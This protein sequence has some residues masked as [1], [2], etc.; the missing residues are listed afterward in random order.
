MAQLPYLVAAVLSVA[1]LAVVGYHA[2]PDRERLWLIG[3]AVG[4]G[5]LLEQGAIV[6]FE[7]YTY[8]LD[9]FPMT[10]LDVPLTI[11]FAWAAIVYS[12]LE[13]AR[14]LDL[15]TSAIPAFTA[16][17]LLHVDL[18]IDAVAIRIPFWTW[19]NSGAWFGVPINN[20]VGWYLIGLLFS[21][22]YL[23]AHDRIASLPLRAGVTLTAAVASLLVLLELWLRVVA[24]H[25]VIARALGFAVMVGAALVVVAGAEIDPRPVSVL[26]SAIPVT[27]HLFYLAVLLGYGYHRDQPLLLVVAVALLFVGVALHALPA[28]HARRRTGASARS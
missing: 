27:V 18:A 21:G 13:T 25:G 28:L 22:A 5:F 9:G 16:L 20:F 4:Y 10:L 23:I 19:A 7:R 11:A 8:A 12:A 3:A 26:V 15:D 2:S 17:Y 24:V 6:V 1:G 14:A